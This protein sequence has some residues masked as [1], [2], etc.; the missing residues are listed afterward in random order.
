MGFLVKLLEKNQKSLKKT[1]KETQS[2]LCMQFL[3]LKA[4][5]KKKYALITWESLA[6]VVG[7][8]ERFSNRTITGSEIIPFLNNVFSKDY[9][10]RIEHLLNN[11]D[12]DSFEQIKSNVE[13]E[14]KEDFGRDREGLMCVFLINKG[15]AHE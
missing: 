1:E 6:Y 10:P 5:D 2:C 15:S 11:I 13:S 7:I 12:L 3:A 4:Y 14:I 8:G 9:H